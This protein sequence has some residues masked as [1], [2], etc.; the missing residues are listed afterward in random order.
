MSEKGGAL[1]HSIKA[2]R[3]QRV[4][5]F[6]SG[7]GNSNLFAGGG[8]NLYGYVLGDP[9]NFRGVAGLETEVPDGGVPDGGSLVWTAGKETVKDAAKDLGK[10]AW[11]KAISGDPEAFQKAPEPEGPKTGNRLDEWKDANQP[12]SDNRDSAWEIWKMIAR[13]RNCSAASTATAAIPMSTRG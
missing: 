6:C 3:F 10:R 9:V 13:K 8:T 7:R 1:V 12:G 4:D 2:T 5:L 11:D